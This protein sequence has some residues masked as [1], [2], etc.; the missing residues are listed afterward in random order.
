MEELDVF[1]L[2]EEVADWAWEQV[3]GW[4][5][6]H[7]DT[8]GK[9]L[10]RSAD[11][12]GAN[13]VEGDGRYTDPDALH[14]FVVARASAR[15]ARLWIRRAAKRKLVSSQDAQDQVEKLTRATRLLNILMGYRRKSVG[16][17]RVRERRAEYVADSDP[18]VDQYLNDRE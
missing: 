13:L 9:Q 7:Q 4:K 14:F 3:E 12:V 15:E 18:F 10:V 2:F 6:R 11:S 1:I 5:P 16:T 8:L 17:T